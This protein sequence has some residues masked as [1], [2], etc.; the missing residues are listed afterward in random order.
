MSKTLSSIFNRLIR[1]RLLIWGLA[2]VMILFFLALLGAIFWNVRI[3]VSYR[4]EMLVER[5]PTRLKILV[6]IPREP[7]QLIREGDRA[8]L[9]LEGGTV[10]G[11]VKKINRK[12][13][14]LRLTVFTSPNGAGEDYQ[15]RKES[16][17]S[18]TGEIT[19]RSLRLIVAF[20]RRPRTQFMG[21]D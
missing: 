7:F 11:E 8:D 20:S 3:K 5:T 18:V 16:R 4:A 1:K 17:V 14:S 15:S 13:D 10:R 12:N 9:V 2:L 19:L 6:T 21:G